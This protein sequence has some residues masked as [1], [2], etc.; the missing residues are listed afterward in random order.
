LKRQSALKLRVLAGRGLAFTSSSVPTV[1]DISNRAKVK[2]FFIA[3]LETPTNSRNVSRA[4]QSAGLAR[5][6][7]RL[8]LLGLFEHPL[9]DLLNLLIGAD[10][11]K[12]YHRPDEI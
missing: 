8:S 2:S 7:A 9:E 10:L 3:A 12:T 6:A 11:L 1:I 4:V 5:I